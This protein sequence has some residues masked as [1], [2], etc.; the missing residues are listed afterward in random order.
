MRLRLMS[1][2]LLIAVG[3]TGCTQTPGAFTPDQLKS[4]VGQNLAQLKKTYPN[5]ITII[6]YLS[7]WVVN[8]PNDTTMSANWAY[9]VVAVACPPLPGNTKDNAGVGVIP[10]S[11]FTKEIAAQARNKDYN[12][13]FAE[14]HR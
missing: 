4:M 6:Y 14:C 7:P 3:M 12:D 1:L 13:L 9:W 10:Q 2:L 5:R 8:K 11:D